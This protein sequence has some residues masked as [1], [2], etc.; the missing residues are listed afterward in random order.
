[1][2]T[3]EWIAVSRTK[4]PT[5]GFDELINLLDDFVLP[6]RDTEFPSQIFSADEIIAIRRVDEA[7]TVFCSATPQYIPD[8]QDTLQKGEW[9]NLTIVAGYTLREMMKRNT[10]SRGGGD[11]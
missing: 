9:I 8:T 3:L 2:E 11:A 7:V 10:S 1:M 4:V 6:F 5:C